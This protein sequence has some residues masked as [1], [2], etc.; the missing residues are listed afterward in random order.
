MLSLVKVNTWTKQGRTEME[1]FCK[2]LFTDDAV[3][4]I[5]ASL[6]SIFMH[7]FVLLHHRHSL[8]HSK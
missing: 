5:K 4:V 2:W 6:K 8:S 1:R 3:S 7:F